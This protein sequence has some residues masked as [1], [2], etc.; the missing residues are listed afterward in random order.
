MFVKP[1]MATLYSG[2]NSSAYRESDLLRKKKTH[3]PMD[4]ITNRRN[5]LTKSSAKVRVADKGALLIMMGLMIRNFPSC[6]PMQKLLIIPTDRL[7][8]CRLFKDPYSEP[9]CVMI[10][11]TRGVLLYFT[12]SHSELPK[13][14]LTILEIFFGKYLK[15]KC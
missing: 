9:C 1:S 2:M 4:E 10:S 14:G 13:T 7:F 15:E 11:D 3:I 5:N 6:S 12:L 8:D